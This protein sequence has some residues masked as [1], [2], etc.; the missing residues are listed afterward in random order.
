M[1]TTVKFSEQTVSAGVGGKYVLP[2]QPQYHRGPTLDPCA[3]SNDILF[4][5]YPG[6]HWAVTPPSMTN[7]EP[8]TYDDSS[9]ARYTSPWA[10]SSA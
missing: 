4:Y 6:I 1:V 2:G 7:S 5:Q 3:G 10:M 8:V 9:D